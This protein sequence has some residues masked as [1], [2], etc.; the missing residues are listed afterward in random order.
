MIFDVRTRYQGIGNEKAGE[1][2]QLSLSKII[3]SG[4]ARESGT[5][6]EF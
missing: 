4:F 5:R 1:P 2:P 3:K 6:F